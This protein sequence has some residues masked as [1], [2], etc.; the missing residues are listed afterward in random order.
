MLPQPL[1]RLILRVGPTGSAAAF[2]HRQMMTEQLRG[3]MAIGSATRSAIAQQMKAG[4]E[5]VRDMHENGRKN[6]ANPPWQ[7]V[8]HC[9][10]AFGLASPPHS[11]SSLRDTP[12]AACK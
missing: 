9:G 1:P 3:G 12:D 8:R 11:L 6:D 10:G 5:Q 7:E 2:E 4:I